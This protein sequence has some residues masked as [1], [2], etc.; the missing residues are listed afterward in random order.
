MTARDEKT[1]SACRMPLPREIAAQIGAERFETD[2]IGRSDSS[3][4]L[5]S[6]KVLK[7][8]KTSAVSDNEHAVLRWLD[9]KLRAPRVL[10]FAK[11]NGFNYLLMTRL[12]GKMSFAAEMSPEEIS[13]KLAEGIL[14]LRSTDITDCPSKK[15]FAAILRAAKKRMESGAL[16]GLSPQT[17][18]FDTFESLYAYLETHIPTEVPVFSHGDY[19]LPNVFLSEDGIGFLDLGSAGVMDRDYDV[20]MCLWSMRYN[21]VTLGGMTEERFTACK[22]AFFNA[23]GESENEEKLRFHGLLDEFFV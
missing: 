20:F 19:C 15:D 23:L 5:F 3:V 11:E 14:L 12:D 1:N 18:A 17:D 13:A 8:E 4:L 10:A 21:F 7:I 16:K 9:G 6:D 22:R 2:A